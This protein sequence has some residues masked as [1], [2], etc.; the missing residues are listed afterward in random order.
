MIYLTKEGKK[1]F[2]KEMQGRLEK[3]EEEYKRKKKKLQYILKKLKT[4]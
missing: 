2:E 4:L 1:K 3:V